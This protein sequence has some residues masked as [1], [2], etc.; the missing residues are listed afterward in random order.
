MQGKPTWRAHCCYVD[1][2]HLR[3]LRFVFVRSH[4]L[5][6]TVLPKGYMVCWICMW[7]HCEVFFFFWFKSLS[8]FIYSL[9]IKDCS[10]KHTCKVD[11][12]R[13]FIA[14]AVSYCLIPLVV[15]HWLTSSHMALKFSVT[16][17]PVQLHKI[18]L[19][20]W[21]LKWLPPLMCMC[22]FCWV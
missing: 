18:T 6:F 5:I 11:P 7:Q 21:C 14:Y 19:L 15:K 16:W 1:V 22:K 20:K 3:L 4:I 12:C 10:D 13:K 2:Q 9:S 8:Y 17:K